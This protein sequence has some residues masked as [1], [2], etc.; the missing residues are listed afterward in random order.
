M[1]QL[2]LSRATNQAFPRLHAFASPSTYYVS[3]RDLLLDLPTRFLLEN[4]A[5]ADE[6]SLRD[7][8]Y[9]GT[10]AEGQQPDVFWIGC[11]DSRVPAERITNAAPG[12]LF[13]H[14]SIANMVLHDDTSLMSALQYAIR[15]LKVG[16]VIVCGHDGCG[17]VRAALMP[18]RDGSL[19]FSTGADADRETNHLA[20]RIRPLRE[21]YRRHRAE[22]DQ[23]AG[24][25][26]GGDGLAHSVDHLVTLN[27]A[28]QVR[29]LARS[30]PVRQAWDDGHALRLH[31]WVYGLATGRLRRILTLDA[32]SDGLPKVA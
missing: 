22:V 19:P 4:R 28:E 12:E 17:G 29:S 18:P 10:L 3:E 2:Y 16:H 9:F 27:V 31:G 25:A 1:Q 7:P 15:E 23:A 8:T 13:V 6:M 14:R 5:W 32:H 20:E 21:L 24:A 26:R 11:S 30:R